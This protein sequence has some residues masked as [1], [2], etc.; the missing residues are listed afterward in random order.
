MMTNEPPSWELL[1]P[2]QF[3]C[4][5]LLCTLTKDVSPISAHKLDVNRLAMAG[6][7]FKEETSFFNLYVICKW[8]AVSR[9][10][11]VVGCG[12]MRYISQSWHKHGRDVKEQKPGANAGLEYLT[13]E[14]ATE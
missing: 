7:S 1:K 2:H 13:V 11:K 4:E 5:P 6:L 8:A 3:Q 10:A 9:G 12:K 14:S